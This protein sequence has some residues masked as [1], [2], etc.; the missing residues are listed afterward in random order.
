VKLTLSQQ[1]HHSGVSA[2]AL[3]AD[4]TTE[5]QTRP[6]GQRFGGH[7]PERPDFSQL[8][9]AVPDCRLCG[10]RIRLTKWHPGQPDELA[11]R[12]VDNNIVAQHPAVNQGAS[13]VT[14]ELCCARCGRSV[15]GSD[16]VVAGIGE[17]PRGTVDLALKSGGNAIHGTVYDFHRNEAFAAASPFV[18]SKKENRNYNY[19]FSVAGRSLRTACFIPDI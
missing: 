15:H 10:G 17:K 19:G 9:E 8:V 16:A 3:D 13:P 12:R 14:L 6:L 18:A 7:A 1:T 5:T 11:D 4:T 2:S